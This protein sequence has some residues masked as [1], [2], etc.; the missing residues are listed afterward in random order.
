MVLLGQDP[1]R[2]KIVV[3]NECLEQVRNFKQLRCE[4]SN[5]NENDIHQKLSKF[6]QILGI[7]NNAFK[8]TMVKKFSIIK[9][10][11]A[12]DLPHSFIWKRNLEP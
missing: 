6:S 11:N 10:Y 5:E 8:P 12:L 7:L 3:Y 9:V 2:C 4:I 1:A